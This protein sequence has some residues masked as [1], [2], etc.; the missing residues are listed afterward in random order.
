MY[1]I[2]RA[3]GSWGVM[4]HAGI[5][6]QGNAQSGPR[7]ASQFGGLNWAMI[8]AAHALAGGRLQL[9]GM[10]SAD[11]ATVGNRGYPMLLQ[12]GESYRGESIHDRQHPHDVFME[13]AAVYDRALS[14]KVAMQLYIAPAGEPAIGPVAFPHRPSALSPF[15]TIAHHW[16]DA[17]HVSFGVATAALYTHSLKI[18]TSVFNAREPDDVRTNID[19]RGAK[20]NAVAVRATLNPDAFS[21]YSVS[22]AHMPDAE[23]S[24]PGEALR[25]V[26]ASA[27]RSQP[28][29]H[30]RMLSLA[31]IAGGNAVG[32]E[33]WSLGATGEA[34]LAI[35][36][37]TSGFLRAE[38][39]SKSAE[40]LVI[41]TTTNSALLKNAQAKDSRF[42]VSA[43]TMGVLHDL[44][45]SG[46]GSLALGAQG[47]LNLVPSSLSNLYGSRTP[48]G[49][50]VFLRWRP[51]RMSMDNMAGMS[52]MTHMR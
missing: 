16:Q 51:S 24:H 13:I 28:L 26:V 30:N 46:A 18:E 9:R 41:T 6:A 38:A 10:F 19:L 5:F 37:R 22:G 33:P 2:M 17:T 47:T 36:L 50:A 32:H 43:F 11:A 21:S 20:F 7:G 52:G 42:A 34:A 39:V 35:S 15:A 8:G 44:Y 25:R 40:E 45:T 12:T 1:G 14:S 31:L 49:G 48:V 29:A 4:A 27:L 3:V 23:A